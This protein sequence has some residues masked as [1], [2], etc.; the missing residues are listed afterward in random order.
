MKQLKRNHSVEIVKLW[1]SYN[2]ETGILSRKLKGRSST[3]DILNPIRERVDLLGTRYRV[4]HIIWA[5]Y[6]GKWPDEFID[7]KDHNRRNNRIV[8]LREA[9]RIQN[10]QNRLSNNVNG[11]GVTFRQDRNSYPWQAQIQFERRKLH[12]GFYNSKEE[13]AE[14]YKQAAIE[15]HGEFACLE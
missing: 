15:Y 2:P 5:L 13:A 14:A 7:H 4:T 1:F 3:P 9:S 8:N 10:G 12:L 11:K 6:H